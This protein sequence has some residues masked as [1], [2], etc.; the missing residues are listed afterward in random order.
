MECQPREIRLVQYHLGGGFIFL[1]FTPT[2]LG[3]MIQFDEHIFSDGLKPPSSHP[4][5]LLILYMFQL[6][7]F[8]QG[9]QQQKYIYILDGQFPGLHNLL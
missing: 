1:M 8:V 3:E 2:V 9:W 5:H 4:K 6:Q 7:S